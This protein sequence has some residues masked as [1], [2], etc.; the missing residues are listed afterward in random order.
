MARGRPKKNPDR[1][2]I[3]N[4]KG[5]RIEKHGT[6][7]Y[8]VYDFRKDARQLFCGLYIKLGNAINK[9]EALARR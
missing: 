5:I 8:C 3:L 2:S 1:V 6:L 9:G 4:N 7:G